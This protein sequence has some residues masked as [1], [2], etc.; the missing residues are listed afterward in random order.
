MSD[1]SHNNSAPDPQVFG[2]LRL[3]LLSA[4]LHLK[5][6]LNTVSIALQTLDTW[7]GGRARPDEFAPDQ[8]TALIRA[9]GGTGG[10]PKIEADPELRGFIRSH[11]YRLPYAEI[12]SLIKERFPKKRHTVVSA[13]SQWWAKQ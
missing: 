2:S 6:G 8:A 7:E 10:I 9:R 13:L 5:D 12:V 4:E 11:I 3:Q 1:Q